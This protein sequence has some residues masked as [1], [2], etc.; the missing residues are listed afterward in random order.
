MRTSPILQALT[1]LSLVTALGTAGCA[2]NSGPGTGLDGND[3][4]N[5]GFSPA[6]LPALEAVALDNLVECFGV[7]DDSTSDPF[8]QRH[9]LRCTAAVMPTGLTVDRVWV[10][11]I[12]DDSRLYDTLDLMAA[13][14]GTETLITRVGNDHFPLRVRVTIPFR[15]DDD[16]ASKYWGFERTIS[17][18]S[19]FEGLTADAP[20]T[21]GLPFDLWPVALYPTVALRDAWTA[22]DNTL[23]ITRTDYT[24][25]VAGS[26]ELAVGGPSPVTEIRERRTDIHR[27]SGLED[28]ASLVRT[29]TYYAMPI[30]GLADPA[31]M[32]IML[33]RDGEVPSSIV[34]PGYYLVDLDGTA[35]LTATTDLPDLGTGTGDDGGADD[36][37]GIGDVDGGAGDVDGGAGDDGGPAPDPCA[38]ACSANEVCVAG[39][40]VVRSQQQQRYCGDTP[41]R[42]CDGD[43][44]ADCADGN[45]C[46][47]GLC[48]NRSCQKQQ[49][50]G[51][52]P[53]TP[54]D[55]D[56]GDCAPDHA[57]NADNI[58]E[59]VSCM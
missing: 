48:R 22:E 24:F 42:L 16:G 12:S 43:D 25:P 56:D 21:M 29:P 3:H 6:D 45:I 11:V 14:F 58:C 32:T 33:G 53:D 35:T 17:G 50:C 19:E 55:G 44:N 26:A 1:L 8:F 5:D 46:A 4:K 18:P 28:L 36:D 40:C 41:D 30:G 13:D 51:D 52:T 37:G 15:L 23:L 49:Y 34:G 2:V 38:G 27:R 7:M 39:G 57:C 9:E 59:R 31:G 47:E 54:C 10:S 20:I